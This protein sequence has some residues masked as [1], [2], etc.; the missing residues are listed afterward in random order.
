MKT[1]IFIILILLFF[2]NG[3]AQNPGDISRFNK[4]LTQVTQDTSKVRVL[5]NLSLSY[6]FSNF[7]SSALFAQKALALSRSIDFKSGEMNALDRLG[8]IAIQLGDIPKGL[9][10]S[11]QALRIAEDNNLLNDAALILN[12]LGICY[13][14]L[15]NYP[16]AIKYFRKQIIVSEGSNEAGVAYGYSALANVYQ[17]KGQLDSATFNANKA[18]Q[19]FQEIDVIEPSLNSTFGRIEFDKG[20]YQSALKFFNNSL[21]ESEAIK[22]FNRKS[23]TLTDMAK[24]YQTLNKRDS[25]IL[26]AKE[27]LK[28]AEQMGISNNIY[29]AAKFLSLLYEDKDNEKALAYLKMAT[30]IN[31]SIFSRKNILATADIANAEQERLREIEA[32]KLSYQ[33]KL[34][35]YGFLAGLG[36]LTIVA[37][38]LYRNNRRKHN[39][40]IKLQSQKEKIESTLGKLKSTQAQL[41]QS[42]KMASLGELTAGIAHEIQ[43]PLNFVNNF[44][45]VSAELVEE[46]EEERAKS[47]EARDETLVSEILGDIKQNLEKINHHGK[48]ADAIVKGMLEH[49]RTGSGEK[50]LTDINSLA[51]EYL[52]LA[53][54]SFKSKNKDVEIS[55]ITELDPT[56]PKIELVRPDIGKVLLNI[57]N[58]AFYACT[59]TSISTDTSKFDVRNSKFDIPLN[60]PTIGITTKNLG[61]SIQISISDNGPGIP[62][63]IKSKIF[64][65]FFTT[66]PTG[67]GTGLGLSLSYDIVKSHGGELK[68]ETKEGEGSEFIIQLPKQVLI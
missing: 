51:S 19:L 11:L 52:N 17:K 30:A 35:Q 57:L 31:D 47:R 56:I 24:V 44:S 48:R 46:V 42:E 10:Y 40:N 65:P 58:N 20:N 3:Y 34:K 33:N 38:L 9:N 12:T 61:D 8:N 36:F 16:E 54:Q 50:E 37:F 49:S 1:T 64:Q 6:R 5:I 59:S 26:Y 4:E 2:H 39:D 7:D 43:N 27:G 28:A 68:V 29:K 15:E 25:S 60:H 18:K 22:D 21:Q 32:A 14:G 53:Y 45:E 66:K 62:S 63:S 23:S 67:Q 55:L 13:R 41:I